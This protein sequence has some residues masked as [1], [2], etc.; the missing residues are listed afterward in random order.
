ML[1]S[2]IKLSNISNWFE[3]I[4]EPRASAKIIAGIL[5]TIIACEG[6]I[7][8]FVSHLSELIFENAIFPIRADG[9][10]ASGV[11]D[12]LIWLRSE[13]RVLIILQRVRPGWLS[14]ISDGAESEFYG[15]LL[16]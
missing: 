15:M 14:K 1:F 9:I 3:V 5:D 6:A 8:V 12:D 16:G 7:D 13:A 2:K 11:G 4:T 10:E